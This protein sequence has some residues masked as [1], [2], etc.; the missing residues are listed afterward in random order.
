MV[1]ITCNKT[2]Y[3]ARVDVDYSMQLVFALTV[4]SSISLSLP[5]ALPVAGSS[6]ACHRVKIQDEPKICS[7]Q[8]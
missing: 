5:V 1:S 3:G 8:S 2:E 6:I 4:V 7:L